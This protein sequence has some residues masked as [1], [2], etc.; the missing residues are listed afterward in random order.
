MQI[1]RASSPKAIA[2]ALNNDGIKGPAGGQWGPSAINGNRKQGTG[3]INNKLYIG[4][5][6]WNRRSWI[7]DPSTGRRVARPNSDDALIV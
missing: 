3:I 4:Q 1:S 6:I 7:K 2:V 5:Q